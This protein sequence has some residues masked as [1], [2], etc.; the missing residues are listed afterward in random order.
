LPVSRK[1]KKRKKLEVTLEAELLQWMDSEGIGAEQQVLA[2]GKRTDVWMPG[3]CFLELKRGKVNGD[4]VCQAIK[5]YQL[6]SKPVVLIGET[7]MPRAGEG[8][9][10]INAIAG[11]DALC[12]ITWSGART[13]ITALS[14]KASK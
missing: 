2:M 8:I 3:I 7:L 12:F 5:Y 6:Y 11:V 14:D 1:H 10:A 9:A 13:Y 4:D